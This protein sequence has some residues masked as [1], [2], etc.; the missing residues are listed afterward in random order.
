MALSNA[1]KF[2]Q[3]GVATLYIA[4]K[5]VSNVKKDTYVIELEGLYYAVTP[6][7]KLQLVTVTQSE[8]N[9][10][11]GLSNRLNVY[12][13]TAAEDDDAAVYLEDLKKPGKPVFRIDVSTSTINGVATPT[14]SLFAETAG[15]SLQ[16]GTI[17]L[18]TTTQVGT[19]KIVRAS[20]FATSSSLN[21]Y[22]ALNN[23]AVYKINSDSTVS[24]QLSSSEIASLQVFSSSPKLDVFTTN[25]GKVYFRL[26]G[27]SGDYSTFSNGSFQTVTLGDNGTLGGINN[28][29]TV[30]NTIGG[31][32]VGGLGGLNSNVS[33]QL[34]DVYRIASN[35]ASGTQFIVALVPVGGVGNQPVYFYNASTGALESQTTRDQL[36]QAIQNN[37]NGLTATKILDRQRIVQINDGSTS[38]R[39]AFVPEGGT[40]A[41][42]LVTDLNG[43]LA[44]Q[45]V[46]TGVG[47]SG[48]L[49]GLGG[50]GDIFGG[51]NTVLNGG[52][53]GI[54]DEVN[55][56]LN[57]PV[58]QVLLA[59]QS[60]PDKPLDKYNTGDWANAAGAFFVGVMGLAA[61]FNDNGSNTAPLNPNTLNPNTL[62]TGIPDFLPPNKNNGNTTTQGSSQQT[63]SSG[64]DALPPSV[65]SVLEQNTVGAGPAPDPNPAQTPAAST[66]A[67]TP[68][69]TPKPKPAAATP[70]TKQ[71]NNK[72]TV[73]AAS[74]SKTKKE[75]VAAAP[76]SGSNPR[77]QQRIVPSSSPPSTPKE[78]G[79]ITIKGKDVTWKYDET[80]KENGPL[81]LKV[82]KPSDAKYNK[83]GSTKGVW[84]VN[85][86]EKTPTHYTFLVSVFNKDGKV[87]NYERV[88]IPLEGMK[89]KVVGLPD[90]FKET[91]YIEKEKSVN[92]EGKPTVVF[93]QLDRT[94]SG[95]YTVKPLTGKAPVPKGN[96]K[97][98]DGTGDVPSLAVLS[99]HLEKPGET[100]NENKDPSSSSETPNQSKKTTSPVEGRMTPSSPLRE[101]F[102]FF[103]EVRSPGKKEATLV[104]MAKDKSANTSKPVD[105]LVK[106]GN[107]YVKVTVTDK[108]TG[109]RKSLVMGLN[110][111]NYNWD[112]DPQK[113]KDSGIQKEV[114]ALDA[115]GTV[116]SIKVA[117]GP[118]TLTFT[119]NQ[120]KTEYL[121]PGAYDGNGGGYDGVPKNTDIDNLPYT[122]NVKKEN[123]VIA[124]ASNLTQA[125]AGTT[126]GDSSSNT[127]LNL[128][129]PNALETPL[130]TVG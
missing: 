54:G 57:N 71:N 105:F 102:D 125:L 64:N 96:N 58:A 108:E 101:N 45:N 63:G 2:N 4:G 91:K 68:T 104:L 61:L 124:S 92:A 130:A 83:D 90:A 87:V 30:L 89:G 49:G 51:N 79:S 34:F 65:P 84:T 115:T 18:D 123:M 76:T 100:N 14:Y 26:A 59:A 97:Y 11:P 60:V 78:K 9:R 67:A 80:Q 46:G 88:N 43:N 118:N 48:G 29:G 56:V 77:T 95:T 127:S 103:W 62:P 44:T 72:Q 40:Q 85:R 74:E 119:G 50:I 35:N 12:V 110:S 17:D 41:T 93:L 39:I 106:D 47:G 16:T 120:L 99:A 86:F 42:V 128:N 75:S 121:K 129:T 27:S 31:L 24:G 117:G 98:D 21:D 36:T 116:R 6:E 112:I 55:T 38:N 7:K 122:P 15:S 25:N 10:V 1:S 22:L 113:L 126:F 52:L 8:L 73:A 32:G 111:D 3:N 81:V 114:S 53:G 28:V 5:G 37:D 13:Y 33:T 82:T 107:I 69:P 109:K 94:E 66:P 70:E 23:G 20:P 19:G